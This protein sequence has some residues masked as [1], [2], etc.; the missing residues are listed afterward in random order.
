[1]NLIP[2]EDRVLIKPAEEEKKTKSGF[3]LPENNKEKP[4]KGEII[5]VGK[6]KITD[7]GERI[8]MDVKVGDTVYFTQYAPDEIEVVEKGE[9]VKY[10]VIASGSILAVEGK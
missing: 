2:L 9:K 10:L 1:M 6:G 7:D 5:S 3:I 4:S 8:P